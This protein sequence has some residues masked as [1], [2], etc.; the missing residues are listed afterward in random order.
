MLGFKE[1]TH[2]TATEAPASNAN[3]NRWAPAHQSDD[4]FGNPAYD[5]EH[6]QSH[7]SNADFDL[8]SKH[9]RTD[10]GGLT[11]RC[12]NCGETGSVLASSLIRCI[13]MLTIESHDKVDCQNPRIERPFDGNCRVCDQVGHRAADCPEKPALICRACGVEGNII[14][15]TRLCQPLTE[16]GHVA[17]ACSGLRILYGDETPVLPPD[18]ALENLRRIDNDGGA[19][20]FRDVS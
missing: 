4:A 11:G 15:H 13:T 2:D 5:V 1:L 19:T 9:N 20:A 3:N 7:G 10:G 17:S 18:E 8:D 16:R 6:F 12:F 14:F